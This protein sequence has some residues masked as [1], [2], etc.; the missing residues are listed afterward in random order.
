MLME[1]K[2]AYET[3]R[4]NAYESDDQRWAAIARRDNSAD[5]AFYYSVK[6]T[7]VYCRPSC[8]SRLAQR[9]NV[10]FHG[11][12]ESAEAAGFRPCKRCQPRNATLTTQHAN[13]VA[14]ACRLIEAADQPPKLSVL[15]ATVGM[16]P[17]HF[18]R[19]FKRLIGLSPKAYASARRSDRLRGSLQGRQTVTEAIYEAGFNSNS[20][21]YSGA[22]AL[23]GMSPNNFRTGGTGITI[24]FATAK[25]SMGFV[26]VG[27]TV[28]GV[29]TIFLG[30]D[31]KR[32]VED[33]R[34]RFNQANFVAAD[35]KFRRIIK[36]VVRLVEE[37]AMP[38]ELPLDIRGTAFQQKVWQA[39]Q[40]IPPGMTA[41]Y[42]EIAARIK[43]P[44]AV[45][46]VA[47]ACGANPVAIAVPCHRV[48]RSDGSLSGYRWGIER[49]RELL[50]RE[51]RRG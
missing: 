33:L 34:R 47:Q 39:L 8:A 13:V 37:P 45:R 3:S 22:S 21:F 49:K 51:A 48:I 35:H 26:L 30:D 50:Q 40:Q 38:C 19:I 20:R 18:H 14:K 25:C 5:G 27:A 43:L 29:C 2:G 17:F 36:E 6:S 16:S 9:K 46:A 1:M 32:L 4:Q 41:T 15:A 10:V 23:L 12:C 7:G 11:T 31:P 24:R 44:K 28:Q 42:A